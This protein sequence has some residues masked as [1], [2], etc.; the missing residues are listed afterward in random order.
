MWQR[1]LP[2]VVQGAPVRANFRHRCEAAAQ[3]RCAK[4]IG[5]V[6][7]SEAVGDDEFT[8]ASLGVGR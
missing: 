8:A 5:E 1:R 4:A 6:R 3:I 7:V 2:G